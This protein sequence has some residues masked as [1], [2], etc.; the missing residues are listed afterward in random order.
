MQSLLI[1]WVLENHLGDYYYLLLT[2]AV[3]VQLALFKF[4]IDPLII[5]QTGTKVGVVWFPAE[6]TRTVTEDRLRYTNFKLVFKA[7]I[8][9]IDSI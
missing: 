8:R 2:D 6:G 9:I 4:E 3:V 7:A 1:A 5:Q